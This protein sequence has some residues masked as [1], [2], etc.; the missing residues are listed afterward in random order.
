MTLDNKNSAEPM[1]SISDILHALRRQ[2]AVVL[3][4]ASLFSLFGIAYAVLSQPKYTATVVVQPA[5]NDQSGGIAG[6]AS[7]FGAV[8]SLAGVNLGGGGDKEAYLATL[9]S[10]ELAVQFIRANSILPYLFPDRWDSRAG[11][12]RE[13]GTGLLARSSQAL[14]NTL[15]RLSG[16][17]G[18]SDRQAQ[19][20]D[21]EAYKVFSE[22]RRVAENDTTGMVSVSIEARDP[23]TAQKWANAFVALANESIRTSAIDNATRAYEYLGLKAN[24]SSN[25]EL[26]NSIFQLMQSQL[27]T[28]TLARARSE[29]AF[30]VIDPAAYPEERSHPKRFLIV[31]MALFSGLFLGAFL[32]LAREFGRPGRGRAGMVSGP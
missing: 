5:S 28:M 1:L 20:S 32:G 30:T 27:E 26:R 24:E 4:V 21:W 11:K 12:W 6:L 18:H 10:R 23:A 3:A 13:P 15:A 31:I 25:A 29:Y 14:S 2:Q 19:P 9:R 8:A 7:R 17:E 16:D 22:I